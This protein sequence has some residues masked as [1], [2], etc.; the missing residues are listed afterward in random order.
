MDVLFWAGI[1]I[2]AC[3]F[4][5]VVPATVALFLAL[6]GF[7]IQLLIGILTVIAPFIVLVWV[8]KKLFK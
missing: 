1:G 7:T 5:L 8:L 6:F 2:L 3:V 4:L